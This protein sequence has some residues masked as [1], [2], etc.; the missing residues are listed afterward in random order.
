MA[1]P[2]FLAGVSRAADVFPFSWGRHWWRRQ[3]PVLQDAVAMLAPLAAVLLFLAAIAS[4]F[5]YLHAEEIQRE[6]EAVK[7]DVEYAQ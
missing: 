2:P 1:L 3:T 6:Q 7:R 4:A 5:W